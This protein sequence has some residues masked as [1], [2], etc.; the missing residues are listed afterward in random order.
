MHVFIAVLLCDL[1]LFTL[2][3]GKQAVRLMAHC[4]IT[5]NLEGSR[6]L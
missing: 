4:S 6:A 1:C 3:D 2:T 5:K